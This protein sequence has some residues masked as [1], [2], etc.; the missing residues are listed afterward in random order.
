MAERKET[1]ELNERM[2]KAFRDAYPDVSVEDVE[3]AARNFIQVVNGILS[4]GEKSKASE[5]PSHMDVANSL[6]FWC[7][8]NTSLEDYLECDGGETAS[9]P[10]VARLTVEEMDELV[11]EFVARTADWLIGLEV[12]REDPELFNVFIKGALSFGAGEWERN[13]ARL[14]H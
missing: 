10:K 14:G 8:A 3:H 12:M 11:K 5:K 4:V 7:I 9:G 2:I 1:P 6:I 13:R